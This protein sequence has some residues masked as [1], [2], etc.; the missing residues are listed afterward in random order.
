MSNRI[1]TQE[2][3]REDCVGD[4]SGKHNYNLLSLDTT[5]CNLSSQFFISNNNFYTIF[6]DF[7]SLTL[8]N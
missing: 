1:L 2:I 3:Y 4:S 7:I 6:N 5:I 8:L